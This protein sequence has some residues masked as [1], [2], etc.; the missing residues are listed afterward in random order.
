MSLNW[1]EKKDLELKRT[2]AIE[3]YWQVINPKEGSIVA[4]NPLIQE[5]VELCRASD[6]FVIT[7]FKTENWE[8]AGDELDEELLLAEVAFYQ[9]F[10]G[11]ARK[12]ENDRARVLG[13]IGSIKSE[14]KA[15]SSR[16]NGKK[17]GRPRKLL[18]SEREE[19]FGFTGSEGLF[20]E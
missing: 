6:A 15:K 14:K 19:Q 12:L 2:Q 13:E 9:K 17:G 1:Q 10:V 5:L 4:S 16:E 7:A 3:E 8:A 20:S 18:E 11:F